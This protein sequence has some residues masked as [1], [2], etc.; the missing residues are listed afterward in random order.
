MVWSDGHYGPDGTMQDVVTY[1]ATISDPVKAYLNLK[2]SY[3]STKI[4]K[5]S[6]DGKVEGISF[7]ITGN[8]V[9]ALPVLRAMKLG[10]MVCFF[11][12]ASMLS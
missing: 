11:T 8:G 9:C 10:T 7:T 6:E 3:G 1:S 12:L 2:V 5:T 4:V